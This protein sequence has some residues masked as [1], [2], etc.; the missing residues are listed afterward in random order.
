[1]HEVLD[2]VRMTEAEHFDIRAVTLGIS[3]PE[4]AS[5]LP[6][7]VCARVYDKVRRLG[8]RHAAIAPEVEQWYG[9]WIANKRT[10]VTPVTLVAGALS[11]SEYVRLAR[12]L[13]AAAAD[14]DLDFLG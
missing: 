14:V 10:S 5:T 4:C 6:Q 3:Q 11:H 9:V 7:T 8:A 13:D 12:T 2:M 1:M